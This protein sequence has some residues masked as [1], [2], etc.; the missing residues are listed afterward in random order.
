MVSQTERH[1]TG[2]PEETEKVGRGIARSLRAGD[3]VALSGGLAAGKTTLVRG[4]AKSLGVRSRVT[5]PTYTL[6][7]L[8]EA[9]LPIVHV[10]LYR[11]ASV[12]E[13]DD[14]GGDELLSPD[15]IAI[16]EW[17]DKIEPLLGAECIRIHISVVSDQ[18][19]MVE[20]RWPDDYLERK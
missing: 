8:Y 2:S 6:V 7:H 19:R 15:G 17:S 14:L 11:L 3:V 18:A 10:D 12:D 13:F 20:I 1:S 5:S 9:P 4:I 16:I